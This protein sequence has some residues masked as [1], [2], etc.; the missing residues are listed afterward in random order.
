VVCQKTAS[1]SDDGLKFSEVASII[2][3][4]GDLFTGG[5]LALSA[6]EGL[7]SYLGPGRESAA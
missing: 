7:A 5:W 2:Q 4:S 3:A 1:P 6:V